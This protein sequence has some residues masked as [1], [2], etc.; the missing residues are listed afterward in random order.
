MNNHEQRYTYD[1]DPTAPL[2]RASLRKDGR[3]RTTRGEQVVPGRH[4][5]HDYNF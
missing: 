3:Y 4:Q 5:F 2:H 1:A